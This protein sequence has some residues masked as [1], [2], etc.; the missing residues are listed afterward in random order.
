MKKV[1]LVTGI[2]LTSGIAAW[3]LNKK[4]E[5]AKE[6]TQIKIERTAIANASFGNNKSDIATAD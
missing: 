5:P 3:S 1:L 6:T 2:I 4:A